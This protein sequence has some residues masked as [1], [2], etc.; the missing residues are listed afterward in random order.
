M[1][2]FTTLDV[3][4]LDSAFPRISAEQ[5]DLVEAPT[6]WQA[7]GLQETATGY[8]RRLNTG[9]KISFEG[10]F[11]RLYATCFSNVASVWFRTK[12]KTIYV[13]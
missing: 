8:G 12:G 3:Q 6:K 4:D 7:M 9:R 13:S 2:D 5:S 1:R 10:R 11:Y